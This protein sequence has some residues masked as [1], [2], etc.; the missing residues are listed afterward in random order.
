MVK[1]IRMHT[2]DTTGLF[3][4]EFTSDINIPVG[5]KIALTNLTLEGSESEIIID[6][7]NNE[8]EVQY[9]N[10]VSII[11]EIDPGTYKQS[12]LPALLANIQSNLNFSVPDEPI[13]VGQ[14]F[15]VSLSE[16]RKVQ[17][18]KRQAFINENT[19]DWVLE[20][21]DNTSTLN[22]NEFSSSLESNTT[23][24]T[25]AMYTENEFC[26]GGG[27]FTCRIGTLIFDL[28]SAGDA[29]NGFTMGLTRVSG[30]TLSP[31]D[32]TNVDFGIRVFR[33]NN[34]YG[35]YAGGVLE[36]T[37]VPVSYS[38]PLG[39]QN[40]I[41]EIR[42]SEGSMK[43]KVY[44]YDNQNNPTVL[45]EQQLAGY[46]GTPLDG[47]KLYPF[48]AFHGKKENAK[49]FQV[50]YT[51]DPFITKSRYQADLTP[52]LETVKLVPQQ[53]EAVNQSLTFSGLSLAN[54][55]GVANVSQPSQGSILTRNIIYTA[56]NQFILKNVSDSII[57]EL[58]NINLSSFD[59]I[60]K[61]RRNFLAVIAAQSNFVEGKVIY[62]ASTPIYLDLENSNPTQ[63]RNIKAR[64]LKGDLSPVSTSGT[65]IMTLLIKG[66]NE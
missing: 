42:L 61:N 5:S 49:V 22:G 20:N 55:L 34:N 10:D 37:D 63:L 50:R 9:S 54:F 2:N 26:K 6:N 35:Y 8:I 64:I 46:A 36:M 33:A 25:N 62:E 31:I 27:V 11:T 58:L 7:T 28:A 17:I 65:I 14:Q 52:V 4:N 41:L 30:S 19:S 15:R 60:S 43:L 56:D 3:Q 59:S 1:L 21:V 23:L 53:T 48:I 18:E 45:Y 51:A 44:Q 47:L 38:G 13:G 24:L 29:F 32:A 39:L 66:P 57:V 40:D 12:Q 16:I